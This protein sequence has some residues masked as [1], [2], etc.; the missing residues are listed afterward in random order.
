MNTLL[1]KKNLIL[2]LFI[3]TFIIN[4]NAQYDDNDNP[5][6]KEENPTEA[7]NCEPPTNKKTLK[8]YTKAR[9]LYKEGKR[10]EAIGIYRTL[11]DENPNYNDVIYQLGMFHYLPLQRAKF[12]T[13]TPQKVDSVTFYFQQIIDQCPEYNPYLYLYLS[14]INFFIE[15]YK[16]AIHFAN[17]FMKY[18]EFITD[19]N[20]LNEAKE[21]KESARFFDE[22]LIDS[23][24]FQPI[25][26]PG[27]ST[28]ND[29]YLATLSPDED[30]FFFTRRKA[31]KSNEIG[32]TVSEREYFC[33][34][35]RQSDGKFNAG[36]PLP[37]PFNQNSSEGSPTITLN[38]KYLVF[39]KSQG[40]MKNGLINMDLFYSEK[41]DGEW[42]EPVNLGTNINLKDSWESQPSISADGKTLFFVS[43][44]DGGY[45]GLD[46]WMSTQDSNGNWKKAVNAGG[47]INTKSDE[48][49]P[50]IHTDSR[51]L[52]FSSNGHRGLGG[53]DIYR[54]QFD[55]NYQFLPPKNLGYP[56]NSEGDDIDFFVATNGVQ[57]FFS[58]NIYNKGI[59]NIYQ[60]ELDEKM[61]PE[62]V[63]LIK[64]KIKPNDNLAPNTTVELRNE[65]ME[66]VA[67][68]DVDEDNGKY[69]IIKTLDKSQPDE[70]FIL[71]IKQEGAA[72]ET[73]YIS[74]Q[75][76]QSGTIKKDA[77]IQQIEIGKTFNLSDVYFETNSYELNQE[78]ERIIKLFIEFLTENPN[79][80]VEIQG[81]TDNI[82]NISDNLTLSEE[83]AKAVY[84]YIIDQGISNNRIQCK[85]YGQTQPI[86]DNNTEEGRAK[87]RRTVFLVLGK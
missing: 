73:K 47:V 34:S 78:S 14:R 35:E 4:C 10:N 50:F 68:V 60:F 44:R 2:S 7:S 86:A 46:I 71:N 54:T 22:I 17:T 52:Y 57:A 76:A 63:L 36:E 28:Q 74:A 5:I 61:R 87:N 55:S 30:A 15:N 21:I 83:R 3:L 16:K 81:H 37:Y 29:E 53:Y 80:K 25:A 8:L 33:M 27:I 24:E 66:I 41:S 84:K 23:V 40:Y 20:T 18:K 79:I 9:S 1:C 72:Y 38:N 48:K 12:Q 11:Y 67:K 19:D 75:E 64:G 69:A 65:N 31:V 85:G 45:G 49:S 70:D 51:T 58:S 42:S 43:S 26:V 77:D 62:K 82:G 13:V 6:E 32:E 39:T 56:V 59:W